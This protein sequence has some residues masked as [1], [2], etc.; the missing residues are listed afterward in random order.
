[1]SGADPGTHTLPAREAR[2]GTS[3]RWGLC[4]RESVSALSRPRQLGGR[5]ALGTLRGSWAWAEGLTRL[6]LRLGGR[7][8]RAGPRWVHQSALSPHCAPRRAGYLGCRGQ[9][10]WPP[11]G[12]REQGPGAGGPGLDRLMT[13]CP[14]F[15]PSF[16]EKNTAR[17]I[18]PFGSQSQLLAWKLHK[19]AGP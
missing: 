15:K 4:L 12:R 6:D 1:M 16:W 18:F 13:R 7:S 10:L 8:F 3:A 17:P 11:A 9:Q 14:R 5:A 2:P 19:Q